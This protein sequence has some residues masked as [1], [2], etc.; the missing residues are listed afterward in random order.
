MVKLHK[1][2]KMYVWY[3]RHNDGM[4][5]NRAMFGEKTDLDISRILTDVFKTGVPLN[6]PIRVTQPN[7]AGTGIET[8][9]VEYHPFRA[10]WTNSAHVDKG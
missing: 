10:I 2:V 5:F 7:W 3:K 9:L 4:W 8:V 6:S 1:R